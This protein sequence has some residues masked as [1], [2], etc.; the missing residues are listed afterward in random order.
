M[1]KPRFAR[2]VCL[3][4]TENEGV[5]LLQKQ[6]IKIVDIFR[7]GLKANL[8]A[9]PKRLCKRISKLSASV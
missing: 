6:G 8:K 5:N 9:V 7:D 3:N 4:D 1:T 2:I